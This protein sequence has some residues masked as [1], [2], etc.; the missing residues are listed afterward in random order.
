[1]T[2]I[3]KLMFREYDIRGIVNEDLNVE[4]AELIGK[5]FGTYIAG[6]NGKKIIVGR[7]N[8]LSSKELQQAL[9]EGILSTGCDVIDIGEVPTPTLYFAVI[10][11]KGD[12][13]IEVTASHNPPEFNGFKL[14]R[15]ENAVFGKE[16]QVIYEI[17]ETKKFKTG[18]GELVQKDIIDE[19]IAFIKERI[20]FN[21]RLKIVIDGGNGTTGPIG[22]RLLKELGCE[23]IELYCTS[24]GNFPNHLPDPTVIEF[25]QDLCKRVTLENADA[26]I[27]YDGDGDRIGVVDNEGNLVFGDK[28]LILY[29]RQLLK[30]RENGQIPKENKI[31]VVFDV[32]CSQSLID[33]I[34]KYGGIP[35][36]SKTGYPNIQASIKKNNAL[37]GGE[38][39]GHM[40]FMDNYLGFDDGIFAS[41]RFLEFLANTDKTVSELLSDIPQYY[42]TPEI[43]I[44]CPDTQKF[45]IVEKVKNYFKKRYDTIDID[46]I[47]IL[48]GDGFSLIRASNTQPILVLRF[49]AK[50]KERLKIIMELIT[51]KLK[52][53]LPVNIEWG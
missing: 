9:I 22:V 18:K 30:K 53:F 48:F 11:L 20:T 38:M 32:K 19:Y 40:Y 5:G 37:L 31:T 14:R 47:R 10:H 26:G 50:T 15:G 52:E 6:F 25:M 28:L 33:E 21:K 49:E 45:E 44:D 43:R 2:K 46:G 36:M 24:D 35:V 7:D 39:S 23:V 8:R 1:M 27:G 42:A 29:F 17:I 51:T 34:E 12:G 13:G 4:V 41:C 16:V 3:N